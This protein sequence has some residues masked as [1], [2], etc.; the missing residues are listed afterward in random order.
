LTPSLREELVIQFGSLGPMV[1]P[2]MVPATLVEAKLVP[3]VLIKTM[4]EGPLSLSKGLRSNTMFN[5]P[6]SIEERAK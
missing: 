6:Y 4:Q 5:H 1:L 3:D 2:L